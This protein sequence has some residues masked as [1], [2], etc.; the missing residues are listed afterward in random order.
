MFLEKVA[1]MLKSAELIAEQKQRNN[2]IT[3]L[4]KCF[5]DSC[6]AQFGDKDVEG[7]NLCLGDPENVA[8]NCKVEL[9]RAGMSDVF[10]ANGKFNKNN[11]NALWKSIRAKLAALQVDACTDQIKSC[12]TNE[13]RCGE[14]YSKCF[15][16]DA[17]DILSLCPKDAL[18]GCAKDGVM[19]SVTELQDLIT[20][21]LLNV[22]N[23][24]LR[25]CEE[26]IEKEMTLVCGDTAN[27][28]A[29]AFK[30]KGFGAMDFCPITT[31]NG[32]TINQDYYSATSSTASSGYSR[33]GGGCLWF[34]CAGGNRSSSSQSSS[35]STYED[36]YDS[37]SMT[38][39]TFNTD[40][41]NDEFA[42]AQYCAMIKITNTKASQD[43]FSNIGSSGGSS[44][45]GW[46]GG[47]LFWAG[48]GGRTSTNNN[49]SFDHTQS[50]SSDNA[51][52]SANISFRYIPNFDK[53]DVDDKDQVWDN[54][55]PN[56]PVLVSEEPALPLANFTPPKDKLVSSNI[57]T[58][59]A[60]VGT[61]GTAA[62]A[63]GGGRCVT[64]NN[65]RTSRGSSTIMGSTTLTSDMLSSI[66]V[67]VVNIIN[68]IITSIA[69]K[70][71]ISMC[72]TGR[73]MSQIKV[74]TGGAAVTMD[75]GKNTARY[76]R[77]FDSYAKTIIR[78]GKAY[79]TKNYEVSV[80]ETKAELK[81]QALTNATQALGQ[82]DY[83]DAEKE[84]VTKMIKASIDAL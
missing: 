10:S 36:D 8:E 24:F 9:Q 61:T 26:E 70:P 25:I 32:Q 60:G 71:K 56:N 63:C 53:I 55:D 1:P 81:K 83:S 48:G 34:L 68:D 37:T 29:A 64:Q 77:I 82:S 15:G 23:E 14:G 43:Q 4:A 46:G 2:R 12:L 11:N 40:P 78:D 13:N 75:A 19:K 51:S 45:S 7:Y 59:S 28:D 17:A 74:G 42:Q 80:R 62:W 16:L 79:A 41:N 73:D 3:D 33:S 57:E 47:F 6:K 76:P 30:N 49:S 39:R 44:Q 54:S 58:R 66:E 20:G 50:S 65:W 35:S 84:N 69:E 31:I 18:D 27:C 5:Q 72:L 52:Y 22:D 21:L 38:L 67:K